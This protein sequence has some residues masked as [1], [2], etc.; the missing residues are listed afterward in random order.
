MDAGRKD[1]PKMVD[2]Q[3]YS[4]LDGEGMKRDVEY[5]TYQC[6]RKMSIAI[7]VAFVMLSFSSR[8]FQ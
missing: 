4:L 3:M 6:A 7:L 5:Q 1:Q 8:F 2:G